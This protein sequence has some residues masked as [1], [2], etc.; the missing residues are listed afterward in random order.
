MRT[1]RPA[2]AALL[3]VT[4]LLTGCGLESAN[5]FTPQAQP[6]QI[7]PI[8]GADGA[9][10][11]VG[12][13]NFTEA[14]ILGKIA[15]I[16]LQAAGFD[17]TDR[18]G[19]P[20]AAPARAAMLDGEVEVQ[21]EYTGTGWLNYLGMPTGIPD[22]QEQYEAV[23][24][25]DLANGLTWLPPAPANNTYAFAVRSEAVPELGGIDSLSDIAALPVEERTFCVESEFATRSDGF[26]PMLEAYGI[27]LGDPQGVP[28]DNVNILDTGAVYT[29]TDNGL[30][31]FGEVFTTD[32]RIP[33]LDLT[34]L[35]DDRAF[36][37]AYNVAPVVLTETLEQQPGIAEV[38]AQIT[39]LLTDD[40]LQQLNARVDVDGEDPADVALDWLVSEGLVARA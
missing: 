32:G 21:W 17:V 26:E 6:A 3:A 15:V 25:A 18:S 13:K 12:T 16:A 37:P 40:V 14:L 27:P 9:E 33:A 30:C 38:F 22:R 28:R 2:A 24:D 20:G 5:T 11:V 35:E 8:P 4:T 34:V 7:E 29:A 1:R 10:V 39:P 31:N 36:F 23:R 19:I